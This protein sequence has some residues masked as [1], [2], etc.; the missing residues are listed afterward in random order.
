MF[1]PELQLISE[2][3]Q[4]YFESSNTINGPKNKKK[5]SYFNCFLENPT[6]GVFV[7]VV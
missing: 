1:V 7:T 2:F 6:I 5:G 3:L 4:S